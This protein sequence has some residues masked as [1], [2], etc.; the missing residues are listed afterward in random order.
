MST[1][2]SVSPQTQGAIN[3]SKKMLEAVTQR[4]KLTLGYVPDD[5]LN[6]KP[7]D[8]CKSPLEIAAHV[9][10]SNNNF[11]TIIKGEFPK[12]DPS[13]MFAESK[14][15]EQAITTREQALAALDE[16][17]KMV[18]AE[19]DTISDERFNSEIQTPFM[20]APM[21][22]WMN[23]PARHVDNHASQIDYIQTI[24]GDMDWHIR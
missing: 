12:G 10:V 6:F 5:K 1:A 23:L 8:T 18:E 4:F 17:I 20:T 19:L 21:I 15:R 3:S 14:R 2:L 16:S 13:E 24:Y 11:L 22:F 9:A 7:A